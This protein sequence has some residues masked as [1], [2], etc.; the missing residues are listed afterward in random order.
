MHL[1]ADIGKVV[2]MLLIALTGNEAHTQTPEQLPNT[3]EGLLLLVS[4]DRFYM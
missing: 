2:S 1:R 4:V 3:T